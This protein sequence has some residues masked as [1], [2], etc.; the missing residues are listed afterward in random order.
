MED[1]TLMV[2][3]ATEKLAGIEAKLAT[4]LNENADMKKHLSSTKKI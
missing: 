4:T 1:V 3:S 2:K